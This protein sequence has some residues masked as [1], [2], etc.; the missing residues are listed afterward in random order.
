MVADRPRCF[1]VTTADSAA[2]LLLPLAPLPP[3]IDL[4]A[5][6]STHATGT[7]QGRHPSGC[8]HLCI[9]LLGVCFQHSASLLLPPVGL[10]ANANS[11]PHHWELSEVADA[12]HAVSAAEVII[13]DDGGAKDKHCSQLHDQG[14]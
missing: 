10:I 13:C 1:T 14:A 8:E 12:A 6:W 2:L 9:S 3:C 7:P 11:G 5:A 4:G